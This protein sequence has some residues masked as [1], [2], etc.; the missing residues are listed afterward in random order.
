MTTSQH[1]ECNLLYTGQPRKCR[2]AAEQHYG[3]IGTATIAG[4]AV[5]SKEPAT[6]K[7]CADKRQ[8]ARPADWYD[9]EVADT[10]LA[11]VMPDSLCSSKTSL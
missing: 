7:A 10:C 5:A 2:G 4:A 9:G 6:G 8:K 3:R 1:A 11:L